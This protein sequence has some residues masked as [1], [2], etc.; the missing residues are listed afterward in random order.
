MTRYGRIRLGF[1][2]LE[3]HIRDQLLFGLNN[4]IEKTQ[5]FTD[6]AYTTHEHRENI[7]L[8]NDRM[9]LELNQCLR[10]ALNMEQFP[11]SRFDI[12]AAID[13]VLNAVQDLSHQL[14]LAVADQLPELNEMLKNCI[15]LVNS[16][17]NIALD[18]ELDRFQETSDRFHDY[19]DHILEVNIRFYA[20]DGP[21]VM[22]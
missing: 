15:E 12:D 8:L 4:C 19:V 1:S 10:I 7:L 2:V 6:S 17:R 9:R 3:P 14:A 18:Q 5:N 21:S 11:N 20:A 22:A 16:L 13:S